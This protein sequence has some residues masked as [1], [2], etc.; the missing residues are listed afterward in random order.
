MLASERLIRGTNS[1]SASMSVL[2]PLFRCLSPSGRRAHLSILAFHRVLPLPD[3]LFPSLP[4]RARFNEILKW[5]KCWFNVLPL[6]QAVRHLAAS[7][8]P[9]RAA[10]ITFDDGYADNRTLALPLLLEHGLTATFFIAT[11]YLDGGRMFNDTVIEAI[12]RCSRQS[13]DLD[14]LGL[15]RLPLATLHDRKAAIEASIARIKYLPPSERIAVSDRVATIA[16][17]DP[18]SD[19]MMTS[20]QVRE[21]RDAGM[22]IGA[23]TVS[24]PILTKLPPDAARQE[25]AG[26]RERPGGSA[27]PTRR[28]VCLP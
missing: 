5:L 2:A 26:S 8:L 24:H 28:S 21:L 12:R 19:L 4:D 15:G 10:A 13:L 9:E 22:Q 18:P 1:S 3:P 6:D 11:G 27:G 23:H 7:T 17:V 14:A 25:I 16:G 20:R